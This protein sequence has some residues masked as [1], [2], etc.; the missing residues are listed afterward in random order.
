MCP[1]DPSFFSPNKYVSSWCNVYTSFSL[2]CNFLGW[3]VVQLRNK[4][5]TFS[6]LIKGSMRILQ[7]SQLCVVQILFI[8]LKFSFLK[9]PK[10]DFV[11]AK[12]KRSIRSDF[13]C[14]CVWYISILRVTNEYAEQNSEL[15]SSDTSNIYQ[16]N[17]SFSSCIKSGFEN[18]R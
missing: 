3:N 17:S 10:T 2:D 12:N 9:T 15:Q 8:I 4:F 11:F 6:T 1:T 7:T 14:F 5:R 13:R 18:F 16:K